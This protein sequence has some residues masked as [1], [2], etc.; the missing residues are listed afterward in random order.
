[1]K[2]FITL[3]T[4]AY[5]DAYSCVAANNCPSFEIYFSLNGSNRSQLSI[6][7]LLVGWIRSSDRCPAAGDREA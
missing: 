6:H 4:V 1:M 3:H 2:A 7:P 5:F